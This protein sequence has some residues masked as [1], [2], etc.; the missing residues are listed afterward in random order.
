MSDTAPV[1]QKLWLL[2][3]VEAANRVGGEEALREMLPLLTD[4]L[5]RDGPL[6]EQALANGDAATASKL[7]HSLKGCM[8]LFCVASLCEE[9]A[10]FEHLSKT[11]P[12]DALQNGYANLRP[13]L[14]QLN[15][16]IKKYLAG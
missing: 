7:L 6:I 16:E 5:E 11:A 1:G 13:Q 10:Q 15:A 4:L 8:P 3:V 14:Q 2:D 9:V 12:A